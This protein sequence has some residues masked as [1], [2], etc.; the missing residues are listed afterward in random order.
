MQPPKL[1]LLG[2]ER[3]V[4]AGLIRE[5][6]LCILGSGMGWQRLL[7]VFVRLHHYQQVRLAP[8]CGSWHVHLAHSFL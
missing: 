7:S 8:V 3:L 6:A 4:I 2:F 5:D 1:P